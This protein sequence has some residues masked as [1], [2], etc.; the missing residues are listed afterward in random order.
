MILGYQIEKGSSAIA[1]KSLIQKACLE[2]QPSTFQF[3]TDGGSENVNSIFSEFINSSDIPIQH[4]IAQKDVVFSN[5]MV[6][7]MNKVIK[8]QFMYHKEINNENQLIS[9]MADTIPIYN[10]IRPQMILGGNTP[11]ETFSG[12]SIDI[13][14]YTYNFTEQKQLRLARNKKNTCK[15]CF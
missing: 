2:R 13:S 12:L 9:V 10:M 3:L 4:I 11:E 8:H 14:R 15:V 6:E 7:A 5:S 1:I